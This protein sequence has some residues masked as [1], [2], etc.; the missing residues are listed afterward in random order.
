MY[1]EL[2]LITLGKKRRKKDQ[3]AEKKRRQESTTMVSKRYNLQP[4]FEH[5]MMTSLDRV[6]TLHFPKTS[7][8]HPSWPWE[9]DKS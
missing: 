8:I 2:T 3:S 6:P 7:V 5:G 4:N 1:L 9:K